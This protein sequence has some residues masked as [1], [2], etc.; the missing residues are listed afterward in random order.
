MTDDLSFGVLTLVTRKDYLKGIGLALSLRVSNPGVPIA[1]ACSPAVRPLV[2]P[3]FDHVIDEE[4]GIRGFAHKVYLDRYSPFL[5]TVF[6]DSDVLAFQPLRPWMDKLGKTPYIACGSYLT[7]SVS[8][9]GL[10]REALLGKLGKQRLVVID[11]AGHALF[12]KPEC[13]SVF[14]RAREVTQDY[15]RWAG[16]TARY[17]DEDAMSIVMTMLDLPPAPFQCGF[18]VRY[19]SARPGTMKMDASLGVCT[20]IANDDG[21]PHYPATMHF[22]ANEAPF[23]YTRQLLRLFRRFGVPTRGLMRLG[24][25]D[26]FETEVRWRGG[27]IKRRLRDSLRRDARR[28]SATAG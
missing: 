21:L 22:A 12:R 6:L 9:F 26:F 13:E 7:G 15:A 10:D 3:Y 14:E 18:S 5:E 27:A 20:F 4:P 8:I 2:A 25:G 11:G 23:A 16:P 24:L 28:R 1:V 19:G 17:A